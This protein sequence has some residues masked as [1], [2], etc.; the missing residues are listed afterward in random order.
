MQREARL[1][2]AH[3]GIGATTDALAVHKPFL[4]VPRLKRYD[5][6]INAHQLEIAQAAQDRGWA[7]MILDMDELRE[8]C[9]APPAGPAHYTPAKTGLITALEG[10]VQHI[11]EDGGEA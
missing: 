9:A 8:A 7:R 1:I 3:A 4:L 5:E 6:H 10:W 11:A 2:V